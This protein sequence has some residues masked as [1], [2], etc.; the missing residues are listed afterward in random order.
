MLATCNFA[1]APKKCGARGGT[2]GCGTAL[3]LGRSI[4]RFTMMSLEFCIDILLPTANGPGVDSAS[5]RNEYQEYFLGLKTAGAYDWQPYHLHVLI[6]L[7][8]GNLSPLEPFGPVRVC[9]GMLYLCLP[10]TCKASFSKRQ[11]TLLCLLTL[12]YVAPHYFQ[13]V[14]LIWTLIT[15]MILTQRKGKS[16]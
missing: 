7:K 16:R 3:L 1:N 6:V 15:N 9:N 12:L 10:I 8:S 2:V 11:H 14:R 4:D 5:N 13:L